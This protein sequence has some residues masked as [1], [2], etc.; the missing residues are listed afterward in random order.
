M[1]RHSGCFR[2]IGIGMLCAMAVSAAGSA[3][4]ADAAATEEQARAG[5]RSLLVPSPYRIS[6]HA[7]AGKIRYVLAVSEGAGLSLPETGE[8]HVEQRGDHLVVTICKDHCGQE[9]APSHAELDRY[10][11]PNP[12]VQ[13]DD[14]V[15]AAFARV[16]PLDKPVDQRMPVLVKAVAARMTGEIEFLHYWTAREAYDKQGGDCTE[17]AVLLAAAARARG[18][19]TRVV[20]GLAYSSEFMGSRHVFGPHMWVQSWDGNRWVSYDA[21]LGEFDAGRIALVI[22]DGTPSDPMAMNR[23]VR[24]LRIVDAA[25]LTPGIS[26]PVER[27]PTI[28]AS[29][30]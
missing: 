7:L 24:R 4:A 25:A 28:P 23:I 1:T 26:I 20:S 30:H 17:F 18:I 13:S 10:L 16:V 8:Q 3:C 21:A 29:A 9:P 15:I 5:V 19:P 6:D 2:Q 14:R 22:G 12:W 27:T 11:Q